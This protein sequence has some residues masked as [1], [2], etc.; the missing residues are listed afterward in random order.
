MPRVVVLPEPCRP[1]IRITAGGCA[2]RSSGA[3]ASPM[4]AGELAM[5]H[6]DQR[7]PGR[8]AADHFLRRAPSR[9]PR[10]TKSLTTGSATSASSS[11][12]R[13][14]RSASWTLASV[15]RASPRSVL[16]TA[17]E[18]LGQG[19]EHGK[20]RKGIG[21]DCERLENRDLPLYFQHRRLLARARGARLARIPCLGSGGHAP[22]GAFRL[23]SVLLPVPLVLHGVLLYTGVFAEEASTSAW[24]TPFRDHL[25]HR[26]IYWLASFVR[27]DGLQALWAPVALAALIL[28]AALPSQRV[29]RYAQ[30]AFTLHLAIAMLAYS[31]FIVATLHA[32]VMLAEQKRLHRGMMPP[33]LRSLPPLLGMEALLFRI[34]FAAF[35]LLTLTL[36]SGVVFSEQ[37]FGRPLQ[38][39][40]KTVFGIVSWLIFGALLWGRY[41]HGWRGKLAV[42]WTLCGF[43]ALVLA[44]IGSKFVLEII[45]QR[46]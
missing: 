41:F 7:L 29:V 38:F 42:R 10:A 14:S 15:R 23:E 36:V 40:H 11:A 39:T 18:P 31:L 2:A 35:V 1:A 5:H 21:V 46:G 26:A 20:G 16:T 4:S 17:R 45:L 13:T 28:P 33:F 37:L 32:L 30:P 3:F 44:Y 6:A 24:P 9:A 8:E 27:L 19:V 43:A 34:I 25:A 12:M 22:G